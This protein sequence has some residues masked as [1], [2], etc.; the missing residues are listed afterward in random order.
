MK[1]RRFV[2][3]S[4][5]LVNA[6]NGVAAD[7][8]GMIPQIDYF[9]H[10]VGAQQMAAMFP[11]LEPGDLPDEEGW[12]V[13][14]LKITTHNGTHMDAPWHFASTMNRGQPAMF[15]DRSEERRVGK[16]GGTGGT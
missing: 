13:E 2:D 14:V 1:I 7:P 11:G 3:L 12:A 4:V 8:P 10:Q 5:P 9:N 16:A 6:E 15:I